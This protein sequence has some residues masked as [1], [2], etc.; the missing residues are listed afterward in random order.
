MSAKQSENRTLMTHTD[1]KIGTQTNHT[2]SA[3]LIDADD[4]TDPGRDEWHNE[5]VVVPPDHLQRSGD[6]ARLNWRQRSAVPRVT[7]LARPARVE[8]ENASPVQSV[9]ARRMCVGV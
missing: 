3:H 2:S 1:K 9:D 4:A 8:L 5:D 6:A 7:E